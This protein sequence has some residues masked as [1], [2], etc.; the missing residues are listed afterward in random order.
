MLLCP[1]GFNW[2]EATNR[3][4]FGAVWIASNALTIAMHFYPVILNGG[5]GSRLWSVSREFYPK[6]L[7]SLFGTQILVWDDDIARYEDV[8]NRIV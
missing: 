2:P 7:S 8:Y 3:V 1:L 4:L 5:A 6:L